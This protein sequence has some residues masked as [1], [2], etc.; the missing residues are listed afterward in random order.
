MKFVED[1]LVVMERLD[2]RWDKRES[3]T[4]VRAEKEQWEE[5]VWEQSE[6]GKGWPQTGAGLHLL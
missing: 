6:Q 4:P 5:L 2:F 3:R 1:S